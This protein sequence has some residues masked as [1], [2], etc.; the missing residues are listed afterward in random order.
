[1]PNGTLLIV[2][3]DPLQREYLATLL[4]EGGYESRQARDGAEAL[5]LLAAESESLDGVL[6]DWRMPGMDGLETLKRIKADPSLGQLP[7]IF[8]TGSREERLLEQTLAAG[9]HFHLTK[10]VSERLLLATV[11]SAVQTRARGRELRARL[12]EASRTLALMDLGHFRYRT[13][14]EAECLSSL[15][16]SVCPDPER[17]AVGLMELLVNAVEHGNLEITYEETGEALASGGRAE[18][19]FRRLEDPR[20][21]SRTAE[22][23][24]ERLGDRCRFRIEDEGPG[25]A[26]ER[27]LTLSPERAFDTH[28]RGVFMASRAFDRLAYEG[29]GNA[30]TA[31]VLLPAAGA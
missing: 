28:G 21:R 6:L 2:D 16:A 14:G 30:V 24:F 20:F 4:A 3:D 9:A 15:L 8:Q 22:V 18:L 29:R 31:E 11:F 23:R 10:P 13:V 1:M 12:Q 7:V 27:Y 25:F 26:W 19:L 17:A 5:A